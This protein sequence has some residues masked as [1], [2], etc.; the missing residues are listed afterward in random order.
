MIKYFIIEDP[1]LHYLQKI[2]HKLNISNS[3]VSIDTVDIGLAQLAMHSNI[4][5]AGSKD[6]IYMY[7]ALKAFY[8]R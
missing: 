3:H 1:S 7:E 5:M 6:F 4:E 8:R 2:F